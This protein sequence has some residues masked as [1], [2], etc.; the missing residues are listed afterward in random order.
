[1]LF[2]PIM[3]RIFPLFCIEKWWKAMQCG[4]V[5]ILLLFVK[6]NLKANKFKKLSYALYIVLKLVK[7]SRITS[8]KSYWKS[9]CE[10]LYV[11]AKLYQLYANE[12]CRATFLFRFFVNNCSWGMK[13]TYPYARLCYKQLQKVVS[14]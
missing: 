1:M 9:N 14:N 3:I 5:R 7:G 12:V 11:T 8:E 2:E 10:A 13:T 4:R 6:N